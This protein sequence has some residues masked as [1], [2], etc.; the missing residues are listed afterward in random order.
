MGRGGAKNKRVRVCI[1]SLAF[2]FVSLSLVFVSE[3]DFVPAFFFFCGFFSLV[4]VFVSGSVFIPGFISGFVLLF[5]AW[6]NRSELGAK[7]SS[8]VGQA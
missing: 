5:L 2:V 8:I 6:F 7:F 1:L 3:F 4:L